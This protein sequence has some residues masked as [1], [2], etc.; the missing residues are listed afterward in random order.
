MVNEQHRIV[1]PTERTT[2]IACMRNRPT[3]MLARE[4]QLIEDAIRLPPPVV[5]GLRELRLA[6]VA[7]QVWVQ[8]VV[9]LADDGSVRIETCRLAIDPITLCG[10]QIPFGRIC[11]MLRCFAFKYCTMLLSNNAYSIIIVFTYVIIVVIRKC[12]FI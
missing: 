11:Y 12:I 3:V 10:I 7:V 4:V 2:N 6:I 1:Q 9:A 8:G 5:L